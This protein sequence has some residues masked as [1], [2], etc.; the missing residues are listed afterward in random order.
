[1]NDE[2]DLLS[3]CSGVYYNKRK[4]CDDECANKK[5][6]YKHSC[7]MFKD[8]YTPLM[9]FPNKTKFKACDYHKRN[10]EVIRASIISSIYKILYLNEL[11][12]CF[13]NDVYPIVDTNEKETRKLVGAAKK[14]Q[15]AY[16]DMM[17]EILL[18]KEKYYLDFCDSVDDVIHPICRDL[19][20]EMYMSYLSKSGDE[21]VSIRLAYIN[22]AMCLCALAGKIRETIVS[23]LS[24]V[25]KEAKNLQIYN[26]SDM[27]HVLSDMIKWENR[28]KKVS[29]SSNEVS[30]AIKEK[31][32]IIMREINSSL[33][34]KQLKDT[35]ND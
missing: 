2:N 27:C 1:M 17:N 22:T 9:S 3:A 30:D 32:S 25:A 14:R 16:E 15:Y 31:T 13:V 6:C 34:Y 21:S 4:K 5:S 33:I 12:L 35:K 8:D 7:Y 11:A 26:L 28:K 29:V 10:A 24:M 18:D 19:R 20:N 23:S